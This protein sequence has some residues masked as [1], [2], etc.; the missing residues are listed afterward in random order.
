MV[1]A[2]PQ[3][4]CREFPV[5]SATRDHRLSRTD[6]GPV[7]ASF[8][9]RSLAVTL[10]AAAALGIAHPAGAATSP[11]TLPGQSAFANG[12]SLAFILGGVLVIAVLAAAAVAA[13]FLHRRTGKAVE[14]ARRLSSL[15]DMVAEG[16]LVCSGMQV[17]AANTSICRQAGIGPDEVGD[18]MISSFISDA[19]AIDHLLSDRDVQLE[20]Q[21]HA[22]DGGT[23]EV[24]IGARTI[25]Y[26]GAPRRLLEIRDIGERKQTQERVSFLA[27]HDVLT[28]LPN[29]DVLQARLAQ[30]IEEARPCA[31][32][33]VD[34]DHFK[35]MND[36][37]GHA[38]G[39]RI[40]RTVADKLKFELPAGTVVARFGGDEFVVLYENIQDSLEARLV[41]Q[42]LR[43]LLNRAIDLGD[44]HTTVGASVGVAVYPYDAACADDLLKNA[45]LALHY[46]KAGGRG[47]CR[48]FT[49]ALGHERQR[50]MALSA[51]L[52]GAIE[53]GDIQAFFQPL[54][55]TRDLQVSGFETLGRWFHPEF[56]AVP[57]PEFVRLAEENGL[58]DPLTDLM[59]QRAVDAAKQWPSDVRVSVNV[60]PIQLNSQF[61]DRVREAVKASGLDPRRLELE[62]T[63]DVLIKDFEQTASM[64]ARLRALG[65][66]VAMDD[67]GAGYTSMGNLRRL[68]F[69]RIKIDRIFT[70][71]LPNHRRSA[72]IVRSMFVLAREL[73]LDVTV[74]GVETQEQF[75]F[76]RDQGCTE[77]QGFLFSQAKPFSAF[78]DPA[79]LKFE[80]A[81]PAAAAPQPAAASGALIELGERRSK[82]AS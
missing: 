64:F 68:N 59:I 78:A 53:N 21:I 27:H 54:V 25:Q 70:M 16:I 52:R 30:C 14:E 17:V 69:E 76:L 23:V 81:A 50:R 80:S 36:V 33:W 20:T 15:F 46:A 73:N 31:V 47:K 28:G 5:N 13:V 51:Q 35:Q 12:P 19:D 74:E 38:M 2:G 26:A 71:D 66:Q 55:H 9:R 37:H 29:R 56:G 43:R 42:Q 82:R 62:V 44:R 34:L 61:V 7:G 57:P 72:A 75:A 40:L 18:L 65:I 6:R 41:G 8:A 39:D 4:I 45:D 24:E 22:R 3:S 1:A 48:Q 11:A 79:S 67:F 77:V 49:E 32:I 10:L 60:S 63:E 58:I